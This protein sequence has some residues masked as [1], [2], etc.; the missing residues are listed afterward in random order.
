MRARETLLTNAEP[1]IARDS[2]APFRVAPSDPPRQVTGR[3]LAAGP[4][5][6]GEKTYA[7]RNLP[8]QI[9]T[10]RLQR[11]QIRQHINVLHVEKSDRAVDRISRRAAAVR[12]RRRPTRSC[13]ADEPRATPRSRGGGAGGARR[14][15]HQTPHGRRARV[16]RRSCEAAT[17]SRCG[18]DREVDE[19][20]VGAGGG[21]RDAL[22]PGAISGA[23]HLAAER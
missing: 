9:R 17:R 7:A 19:A 10:A 15:P 3:H 8:T 1:T 20:A 12:R 5:L 22:T 13:L 18:A 16:A 14:A 21:L 23:H 2:S 6:A 4:R 11:R